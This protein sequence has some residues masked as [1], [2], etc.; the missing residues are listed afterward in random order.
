[1]KELFLLPNQPLLFFLARL[2]FLSVLAGDPG[3]SDLRLSDEDMGCRPRNLRTEPGRLPV[4]LAGEKVLLFA[5]LDVV[6]RRCVSLGEPPDDLGGVGCESRG[7]FPGVGG[8]GDSGGDS[9]GAG[10][11]VPSVREKLTGVSVSG[12][13]LGATIVSS[14]S[15]VRRSKPSRRAIVWTG[16]SAGSRWPG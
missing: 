2:G 16:T 10:I 8:R 12:W 7:P 3:L 5:S 13:N 4:G 6:L 1:M 14:W 9:G 15:G 11:E